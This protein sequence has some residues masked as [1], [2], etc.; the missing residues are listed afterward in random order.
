MYDLSMKV[1]AR[2]PEYDV[3]VFSTSTG[4]VQCS[5]CSFGDLLEAYFKAESSQEMIDHLKA[6]ERKGD[7][8]PGAI[9]EQLLQDDAINYP[10][11]RK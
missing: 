7:K 10:L 6:H 9:Y 8:I 11:P 1:Y 3:Y 5:L 2:I 4:A